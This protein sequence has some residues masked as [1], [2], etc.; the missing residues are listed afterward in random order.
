MK[1][2]VI[3]K[4]LFICNQNEHRSKVAE[5]IFKEKFETKS[6]GLYNSKPV[7]AKQLT[8]ADLIVVMEDNQRTELS[9]RFPEIYMQKQIL[10]L[11]IPDIFNKHDPKLAL[12]LERRME[13]LL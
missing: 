13:E 10:T 1:Y 9:K 4:I 6:A 7:T 11:D 5:Q 2:Y 8:W 12:L 3:M